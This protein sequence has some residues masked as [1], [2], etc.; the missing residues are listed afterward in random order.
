MSRPA[1]SETFRR[2]PRLPFRSLDGQTVIV[3]PRNR[4][5]HVLNS[6]GSAIWQL[7]ERRQTLA[8]LARELRA[9]AFEAD[10]D[11]IASEVGPFL[12]ELDRKGLLATEADDVADVPGRKAPR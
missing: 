8:E 6:T 1:A 3:N 12:A 9:Q 5:V 11:Q 2:A 10:E 4:E 7:L